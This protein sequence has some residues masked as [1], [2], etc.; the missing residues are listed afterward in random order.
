MYMTYILEAG[1]N[2]RS[3]STIQPPI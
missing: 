3:L 1:S 2:R